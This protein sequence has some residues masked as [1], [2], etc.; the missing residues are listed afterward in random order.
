MPIYLVNKTHYD[1]KLL[2]D[3]FTFAARKMK[4][5]GVVAVCVTETKY[6]SC[7]GTAYKGS[8]PR[9]WKRRGKPLPRAYV[10][11]RIPKP[12]MFPKYHN[13]TEEDLIKVR[14]PFNLLHVAL[15]EMSHIFDDRKPFSFLPRR[16]EV[17]NNIVSYFGRPMDESGS[18]HRHRKRIAH[19]K[20]P[21]EVMAE[22]RVYDVCQNSSNRKRI[23]ELNNVVLEEAEGLRKCRATKST[24][25]TTN[26]PKRKR[27]CE[28]RRTSSQKQRRGSA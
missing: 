17:D 5:K 4:V 14:K 8:P 2:K 25:P 9:Q 6:N 24:K 15:H 20:R 19:D 22:N 16:C 7:Y 27:K 28:S 12:E 3:V 18:P 13:L 10:R 11:F 23:L 1:S 21:C 26:S